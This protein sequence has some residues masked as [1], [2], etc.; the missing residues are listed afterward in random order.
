MIKANQCIFCGKDPVLVHLEN[1]LSIRCLASE[2]PANPLVDNF[3][4]TQKDEIIILWNELNRNCENEKALIVDS[5]TMNHS[6][7]WCGELA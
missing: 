1:S 4:K 5:D 7:V 3:L 2:C 6:K